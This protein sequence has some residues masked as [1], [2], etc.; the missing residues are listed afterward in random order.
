MY[1]FV[2]VGGLPYMG[3]K[4]MLYDKILG[5]IREENPKATKIY[6]LFGGGGSIS[7][8]ASQFGFKEV[9]YN[10]I[11]RGTTEL[12]R[13]VLENDVN[14]KYYQFIT[15]AKFD[16]HK[17]NNDWFG[18]FCKIVYSFGTNKQD[19]L[20][21]KS[22]QGLK[23]LFHNCVVDVDKASISLLNAKYGIQIKA[24][25]LKELDFVTSRR[26]INKLIF[27]KNPHL[28]GLSETRVE[29]L[30]RVHALKKLHNDYR[31]SKE[32]YN[33]KLEI[34]SLDYREVPIKGKR[35]DVVIYLDPP[36]ENRRK[37]PH[38][39]NHGE[40]REWIVNSPYK[41]YMSGYDSDL[42]TVLKMTHRQSINVGVTNTKVIEKLFSN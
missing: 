38:D 9:Y 34:S 27:G 25:V 14:P 32:L 12:L 20:Y 21:A 8:N 42:R 22:K 23:E 4:R 2:Q 19:Y 40:L 28:R 3:G 39:I 5:K 35:E 31:I 18:G 13:D 6:D 10:E 15:R 17:K 36:Y 24:E 1:D 41:I 26:Y 33:Y 7:L 16:K 11:D 29:H 30:A 37:Y